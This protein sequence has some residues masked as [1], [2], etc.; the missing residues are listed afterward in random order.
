MIL[1]RN[2][3]WFHTE[4][5]K[6]LPA[7]PDKATVLRVAEETAKAQVFKPWAGSLVAMT[8]SAF[9]AH[10]AEGIVPHLTELAAKAEDLD[11]H[12]SPNFKEEGP[13]TK[14]TLGSL[15]ETTLR[16]G[17]KNLDVGDTAHAFALEHGLPLMVDSIK[18]RY[19][20]PTKGIDLTAW[21][22]SAVQNFIDV[23]LPAEHANRLTETLAADVNAW[24]E[25]IGPLGPNEQRTIREHLEALQ[26][27]LKPE[28]QLLKYGVKSVFWNLGRT[29][30][31]VTIGVSAALSV[32]MLVSLG[33]TIGME[34]T[35]MAAT[36]QVIKTVGGAAAG[37]FAADLLS[38]HFHH[39][40]DNWPSGRI[41]AE[42]Q[43][44][45]DHPREVSTWSLTRNADATSLYSIPILAGAL[46]LTGGA[47][48]AV[49]LTM[50]NGLVYSQHLHGYAHQTDMTKVP[51]FVRAMWKMHLAISPMQHIQGHHG[52]PV[53]SQAF[54]IV[55][56]WSNKLT[57]NTQYWRHVESLVE[58]FTAAPALWREVEA[59]RQAM[60]A[61]KRAAAAAAATAAA[62]TEKKTEV[63]V[64]EPAAD[65]FK[66]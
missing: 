27:A 34:P 8:E 47:P 23:G 54:G 39:K 16:K 25:T 51:R 53:G 58:K 35:V 29:P 5:L 10:G 48:L 21:K 28:S 22:A 31:E 38:A 37:W 63:A 55:N 26:D 19:T 17:A 50:V 30:A 18:A 65:W 24:R 57:D 42:F 46:M 45:H 12:S 59:K 40:H 13:L 15:L 43:R 60:L 66:T 20:A 62:T 44:H 32:A 64:V 33:L 36:W 41:G 4:V 52:R 49:L 1:A 56:G 6:K 11:A 14:T 3:H 61:A 9:D 2:V 7:N